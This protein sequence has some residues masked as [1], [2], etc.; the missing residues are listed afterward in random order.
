MHDAF[1]D[2]AIFW[3]SKEWKKA[4]IAMV[5]EKEVDLLDRLR[6]NSLVTNDGSNQ[7]VKVHCLMEALARKLAS[8]KHKRYFKNAPPIALVKDEARGISC[9]EKYIDLDE[10]SRMQD[11][12][13]VE[14]KNCKLHSSMVQ[15]ILRF[16][17]SN[18]AHKHLFLPL[19]L[20][21][22]IPNMIL[23]IYFP[24]TTTLTVLFIFLILVA[25]IYDKYSQPKSISPKLTFLSVTDKCT[26]AKKLIKHLK[27]LPCIRYLSFSFNSQLVTLPSSLFPAL[28]SLLYLDLSNCDS[29]VKLPS[30]ISHMSSL[31]T[32]D[33]SGCEVLRELPETISLLTS[34]E[35]L[36]LSNCYQLATLPDAI[37]GLK[38]LRSVKL[39]HCSTLK[40]LPH[41]FFEL[42][43]LQSLD[44]SQSKKLEGMWQH[45][46]NFIFLE[47]LNMSHNDKLEDLPVAFENLGSLKVLN[48][49]NCKRL[50]RLPNNLQKMSSL[51]ELYLAFCDDLDDIPLESIE[52][53]VSLK[54]ISLPSRHKEKVPQSLKLKLVDEHES[55]A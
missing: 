43:S 46:A 22:L 20:A 6:E 9:S 47:D 54:K 30:S 25:Y 41:T 23:M 45:V 24:L 39:S 40:R 12:R 27:R 55:H 21:F 48:L 51:K 10:L 2:A 53:I 7:L 29:L 28:K 37:G 38:A 35:T 18:Q 11:L 8:Q 49:S 5:D 44:V 15:P 19:T 26:N 52:K 4:S 3:K 36:N 42:R 50:K 32:L 31:K 14:F 17:E 33:L 1:L 16:Y 34:L 13:F